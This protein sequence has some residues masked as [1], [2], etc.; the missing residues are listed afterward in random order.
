[1]DKNNLFNESIVAVDPAI[2][3][4]WLPLIEGKGNWKSFVDS[5]P[6]LTGEGEYNMM[7]QILENTHRMM[8]SNTSSHGDSDA[9][10]PIIM[11]LARRVLADTIGT[12]IFGLQPMKAP[13]QMAF[14]LRAT[15]TGTSEVDNQVDYDNSTI[16]TLAD[17]TLFTKGTSISGET[18]GTGTVI[19]K[20]GNNILVKVLTGSFTSGNVD[21]AATYSAAATTI[22]AYYPNEMVGMLL[23]TYSGRYTTAEGEA[24]GTDMSEIG[25][26]IKHATVTA[27]TQKLKTK[28]TEELAEDLAATQNVSAEAILSSVAK[29]QLIRE[30]NQVCL[31]KIDANTGT[32]ATW[33]YEVADGR[34]EGEKYLNFKSKV[35]R[36][37]DSI[38]I[39]NKIGPGT[40]AICGT[41]V[42][43]MIE[44]MGLIPPVGASK[45]TQTYR[46]RALGMDIYVDL[47]GDANIMR[48]GRKGASAADTGIV[49]C[50]YV[51]IRMSKGM[52]EETGQPVAFF[53][54]RNGFLE[55]IY[56]T[57]DFY[58][59]L[60]V[61]NVPA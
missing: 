46:G 52:G 11:G 20:S 18:I 8:E 41:R 39:K 24:L 57:S 9:F 32:F 61:S 5:C 47:W 26:D 31:T 35:A 45:Y 33:D 25:I 7:A 19:F 50:P 4:K 21:D 16:L 13:S 3:E 38:T 42:L 30:L 22:A 36:V 49:F 12:K 1:M 59:K 29:D 48:I 56:G 17:A 54:T 10:K 14:A 27:K 51:P 43:N 60:T 15:Y 6:V 28:W 58:A 44:T 37:R 2:I 53:R 40:F 23:P 34:Y 55:N